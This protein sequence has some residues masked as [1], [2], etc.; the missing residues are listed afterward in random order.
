MLLLFFFDRQTISF[1][2]M[3]LFL[4]YEGEHFRKE[5]GGGRGGKKL[6]ILGN[7]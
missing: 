5:R 7:L 2:L 6:S 1:F 3:K 4:P